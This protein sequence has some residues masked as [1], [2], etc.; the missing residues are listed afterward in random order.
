MIGID[1]KLDVKPYAFDLTLSSINLI[2][3]EVDFF[4]KKRFV[5]CKRRL[6]S[7]DFILCLVLLLSHTIPT[8][9]PM[10]FYNSLV[11]NR[12]VLVSNLYFNYKIKKKL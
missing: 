10:S 2:T 1:Q 5:E 4:S 8:K 7:V 3:I 11:I 9:W 6:K 12:L